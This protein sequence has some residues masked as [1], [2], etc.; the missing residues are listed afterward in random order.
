MMRKTSL[1]LFGAAAGVAVTLI[2]TQPRILFDGA[3][4]QAAAADS[5]RQQPR[6]HILFSMLRSKTK[7]LI[8]RS[9]KRQAKK[10]NR[11]VVSSSW[12]ELP[13]RCFLAAAH[14]P[15]AFR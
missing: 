1:I 14:R 4:A 11:R 6:P 7:Q 5:Y 12:Q 13:Q 2:V 10:C 15:I 9:L 3:R 8:S